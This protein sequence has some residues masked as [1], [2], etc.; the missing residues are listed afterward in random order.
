MDADQSEG[1]LS[2]IELSGDESST[3]I[4]SRIQSRS[5]NITAISYCPFKS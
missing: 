2:E 1:E 3:E 5:G 4:A